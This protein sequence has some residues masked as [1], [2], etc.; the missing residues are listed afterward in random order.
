MASFYNL[1]INSL[2]RQLQYVAGCKRAG[3]KPSLDL[4]SGAGRSNACDLRDIYGWEIGGQAM[5]QVFTGDPPKEWKFT[6]DITFG[7]DRVNDESKGIHRL[8][9]NV[10]RFHH[11]LPRDVDIGAGAGG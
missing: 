1:T 3:Q 9:L 6:T 2:F 10:T 5:D 4:F 11:R 7:I 8:K